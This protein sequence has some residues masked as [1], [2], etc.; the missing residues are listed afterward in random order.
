MKKQEFKNHEE[1]LRRLWDISKFAKIW[2]VW[3]PEREEEEEE[4]E[5]LF[6][7]IKKQ[8]DSKKAEEWMEVTLTSSQNQSGIATKLWR[9]LPA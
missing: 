4:I 6:Q 1:S 9:N 2:I 3:V 5:I 7:K 8:I